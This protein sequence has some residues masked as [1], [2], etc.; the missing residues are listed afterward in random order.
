MAV[1]SHQLRDVV[2]EWEGTN[3]QGNPVRGQIRAMGE[4]HV[5][6]V[7]R[8]Q[9]VQHL[10][11][12]LQ[13]QTFGLKG[14]AIKPSDIAGFTRQLA[15]MMNAGVPLL[16]CFE[17]ISRG[18]SH[19]RMVSLLN[20][21]RRDVET[22]TSLSTAF[23]KHPAQFNSLY[24]NLVAAGEA[25]GILDALLDRLAV[26][27][28]KTEAMKA[29]VKSA[30]TYPAAVLAVALAVVGIIMIVV[31]PAFQGVF[32]SFGADLPG[33]TL[34][35]MGVSEFF[36]AYWWL[37]LGAGGVGLWAFMRTWRRS[38]KLQSLTDRWLLKLPVF[39]VLLEKACIAK[40]TR[41]LSTMFAAG[42]PL[43]DA[44]ELAGGTTGNSVY[45]QASAKIQMDVLAGTSLNAAMAHTG[46][47]PNMVVQMAAI[48]EE[49]GSLDH[50]LGK[51][52]EFFE[53]EVDQKV[54]ALASLME[55]F[56]IVFLG[57]LIGGIVVSMY[58]PIFELGQVI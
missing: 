27:M 45:A 44:L 25:A 31:I 2:F 54:A 55:P 19:P 46:V 36:V 15:S 16:Q 14:R 3:R 7:L 28:E 24:C 23:G 11:V 35:V 29:K 22:G 33:P 57:A 21:I 26:Y 10:K 58:L 48:G 13:R 9:G 12:S 56:I 32:S 5:M 20:A 34:F 42:V 8:R 37:V 47:F 17:V 18:H 30:L 50:M 53:A 4:N 41:T 43:M 40:W 38:E 6:A 39:G 49:S 52:A 1:A 51:A